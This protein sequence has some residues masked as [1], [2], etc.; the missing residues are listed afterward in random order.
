[1]QD[2]QNADKE[3]G[4]QGL[5]I[6]STRIVE[7]AHIGMYVAGRIAVRNFRNWMQTGKSA[8]AQKE[9]SLLAGC[10]RED[11]TTSK[12]VPAPELQATHLCSHSRMLCQSVENMTG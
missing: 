11:G 5:Q 7:S 12:T 8:F 1:M 10:T 3:H 9:S 4:K 2:M 6:R